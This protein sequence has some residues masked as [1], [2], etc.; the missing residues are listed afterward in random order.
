MAAKYFSKTCVALDIETTD[1]TPSKG[2]II[3]I[4]AAKFKKGKIIEEYQS[5]VNPGRRIP[6]I[7]QSITG[8]SDSDV[9][10][11][12]AIS[13]LIPE[14]KKFV[15][16]YAIVGHNID[17]DINFL[18][19]KGFN[20]QNKKYDTW[21]LAAMLLP[22]LTSHSLESLTSFFDIKHI[23]S[24]RALAD[25]LASVELFNIL[26][27]KIYDFDIAVLKNLT[28][29]LKETDWDLADIFR[30]IY[31]KKP[32][33]AVI[34]SKIIKPKKNQEIKKNIEAIDKIFKRKAKIKKIFTKY[35]YRSEQ[36]NLMR[37]LLENF[38]KRENSFIA[39]SPGA[40]KD[41]AYLAASAYHAN[42]FNQSVFI[43]LENFS[44]IQEIISSQINLLRRILAFDFT[45]SVLLPPES[46]IC[47]RRFN[48]YLKIRKFNQSELTAIVKL[49]LWLPTTQTGIFNETAWLYSDQEIEDKI[50]CRPQYCSQKKCKNYQD[51]YYHKALNEAIKSDIVLGDHPAL[52]FHF[53]GKSKSLIQNIIL[54]RAYNLAENY[55]AY[56][57]DI[58]N[59]QQLLSKLDLIQINIKNLLN[60]SKNSSKGKKIR[61]LAN[62]LEKDAA[63]IKDK[64]ALYFG[65]LGIMLNKQSSKYGFKR[66]LINHSAV[67]LTGWNDMESAT[68]HFISQIN[69]LI[70]SLN[71][72]IKKI[73]AKKYQDVSREF[74]GL[75]YD[76]YKITNKI[77]KILPESSSGSQIWLEKYYEKLAINIKPRGLNDNLL[78]KLIDQSDSLNIVIS[79]YNIEKTKNFLINELKISSKIKKITFESRQ[80]LEEKIKLIAPIDV[81]HPNDINFS[82]V[83]GNIIK[84]IALTLRDK[85]VISASS[86][87]ILK[88]IYQDLAADLK[89]NDINIFVQGVTGGKDKAYSQ[90]LSRKDSILL[91]SNQMVMDKE[92]PSDKI[93]CLILLKFPFDMMSNEEL[94]TDSTI[95]ENYFQTKMLPR[96]V[97]KYMKIFQK[98]AKNQ[99]GKRIFINL[100]NRLLNANYGDDFI[101]AL[102]EM[103]IGYIKTEDIYKE[104]KKWL[105]IKTKNKNKHI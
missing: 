16:D 78:N 59:D 38:E 67:N 86:R 36:V 87:A 2:E 69:N 31:V 80:N 33:R 93:K 27:N 1:L 105:N 47:L 81:P 58:I 54:D 23:D 45:C 65:I 53:F 84:D 79:I 11:A 44:K 3:E 41:M 96:A 39:I 24:H 85:V 102:P 82:V 35:E 95:K 51:C 12:P 37:Q 64:S 73:S 52:F 42:N 6:Q 13:D 77:Q 21:K 20:F 70:I 15:G 89:K 8:I 97:F 18:N 98:I 49:L 94:G 30:E 29:I 40:G 19:H 92:F 43:C 22:S 101:K 48:Y 4:A 76:L 74:Q 75:S 103:S 83:A 55:Q 72:I 17:F 60:C 56:Y 90:F 100:D 68:R 26:V 88:K 34:S 57:Q 62:K 71:A 9:A 66:V 7:V 25:V 91:A 14:F 63:V 10:E 28:V 50:N 32:K 61:E 5:L 99:Q 104:V 46:Y